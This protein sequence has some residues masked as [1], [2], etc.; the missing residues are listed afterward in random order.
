MRILVLGSGG[1][2][3]ALTQT[4]SRQGHV[5]YCFPGNA[6][7]QKIAKLLPSEW[8]ALDVHDF[9]KL[10]DL[11]KQL[12]IDLTVVGPEDLLS[13]GIA[14]HFASQGLL[15]FGPTKEAAI[16]ETSKAWAKQFMAKHGVPTAKYKVCRTLEESMKA[17]KTDFSSPDLVIKPS[18]LT[19]GK[20]VVCCNS[21]QEAEAAIRAIMEDKLYGSAGAEIVIEEKLIGP[22][23]S[24]L[25]FC[26]GSHF[27]PMITSQDHKRLHDNDE[28]PNT[29]GMGAYAPVP[30]ADES[31]MKSIHRSILDKTLIGLK[32]ERIHYTGVLY[33]GLML[34]NDGP[35]VLE[36]NCRF[37]DPRNTSPIALA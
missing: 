21:H 27:L 25:V 20:G 6:G 33:F 8:N 28:G 30:L 15:L 34:T 3:H 14:N 13:K 16:L 18:G 11:V 26:D 17:L 35:K 5:V 9:A 36:F 1:R 7:T 29:G 10:A 22:E 23:L 12:H 37:G 2:E 32:Q 19:G 24:L 4:F 31:L